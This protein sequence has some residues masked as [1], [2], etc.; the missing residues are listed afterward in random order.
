MSKLWT[1]QQ[2]DQI[3][4]EVEDEISR[5]DYE[6]RFNEG[7][8]RLKA[9]MAAHPEEVTNDPMVK[10]LRAI[11]MRGVTAPAQHSAPAQRTV[12][13]IGAPATTGY[14][15]RQQLERERPWLAPRKPELESVI[16]PYCGRKQDRI[17][18]G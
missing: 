1:P 7:M 3:A 11:P 15:S 9:Y 6:T 12:A 14:K 8:E 13:P 4:R 16:D 18:I 10:A 17:R 5:R 2:L